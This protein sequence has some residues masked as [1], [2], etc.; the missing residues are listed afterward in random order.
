MTDAGI[1]SKIS[2][3]L[4]SQPPLARKQLERLRRTIRSAA[5]GAVEF[6][7]YGMPG[8]RLEGR[9]LVWYAG[10]KSH[11]SLYPITPPIQRALATELRGLGVSKGTVRFP[12]NEPP[13]LALIRRLVNARVAEVRSA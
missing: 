7:S 12:L 5:P 3:Y 1:R 8:F 2:A 4:K 6:F 11:T 10:W 9:T 13:T